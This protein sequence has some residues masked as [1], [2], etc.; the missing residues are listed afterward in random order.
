MKVAEDQVHDWFRHVGAW[1]L[2]RIVPA[3]PPTNVCPTIAVVQWLIGVIAYVTG[4]EKR[5]HVAQNAKFYH[6]SNCQHTEPQ[7]AVGFILG[8]IRQFNPSA[9]YIQRLKIEQTS[10]AKWQRFKQS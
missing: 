3:A 4:Y 7:E 9:Y 5:D 8:F 10:T 2:T 6:F 1:Q